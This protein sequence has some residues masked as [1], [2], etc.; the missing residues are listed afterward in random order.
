[1]PEL[2]EVETIKRDLVRVLPGLVIERLEILDQRVIGGRGAQDFG[3]RLLR[4]TILQVDRQ[5]KAVICT[6]NNGTHWIVQPKMTGQ[7]IFCAAGKK[8][9][10]VKETKVIVH[11]SSG[12]CLLYNDQRLFGR[13][14]V[15]D[16]LSESPFLSQLGPDPLSKEFTQPWLYQ[17]LAGRVSP[18]KSLLMNQN[19]VAGIGNIYASEILFRSRIHPR[20]RARRLSLKETQRL[21]KETVA[22]LKQAID[23]RGT[24]TRNYRDSRGKK[25]GYSAHLKVY[26]R[27]E[28]KCLSC[29]TRICRIVQGQRSTF[30]CP[31]CQR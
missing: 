16:S 17:A 12:S 26:G 21:F 27:H 3:E 10:V 2:P 5:G 19:F 25:G 9:P 13:L 7:L 28:K 11:F 20:R 4:R 29:G 14:T 22:V 30:F 23:Y 31:Q 1:M 24:S 18:I 6:L 8:C 15:V